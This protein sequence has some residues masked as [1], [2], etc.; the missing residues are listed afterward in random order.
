MCTHG[1]S[2]GISTVGRLAPFVCPHG[3]NR[4]TGARGSEGWKE[5]AGDGER[6][7][8]SQVTVCVSPYNHI[9]PYHWLY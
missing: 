3:S 9:T 4:E 2:G 8:G 7:G 6:T 5:A 1:S